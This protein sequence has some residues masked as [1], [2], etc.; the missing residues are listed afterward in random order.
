MHAVVISI[1]KQAL[2]IAIKTAVVAAHA[3][4]HH[5]RQKVTSI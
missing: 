4:P 2:V 5:V 1:E 3:N